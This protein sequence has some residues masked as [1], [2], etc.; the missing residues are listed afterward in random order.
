[1]LAVPG[2]DFAVHTD[3]PILS[4]G[5]YLD[6][7]RHVGNLLEQ[8]KHGE[9]RML[10]LSAVEVLH[11]P[12]VQA[13]LPLV[14]SGEIPHLQFAPCIDAQC[15]RCDGSLGGFKFPFVGTWCRRAVLVQ[16]GASADEAWAAYHGCYEEDRLSEAMVAEA[17]SGLRAQ[18][19]IPMY[20]SAIAGRVESGDLPFVSFR[21]F[22]GTWRRWS[23]GA[24][25]WTEP[26]PRESDS[27]ARATAG[28]L[29]RGWLDEGRRNLPL[30][31]LC[32]YCGSRTHS[33]CASCGIHQC[34][35]CPIRCCQGSTLGGAALS[36][37]VSR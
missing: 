12:F 5:A 24:R 26:W 11:A 27:L 33:V 35:A 18:D 9:A 1:M 8:G 17:G 22:M 16:E 10:W 32:A 23:L 15:A 31:G 37:G 21:G 30:G 25:R 6:F 13:P 29:L 3:R 7:K 19:I 20:V 4:T 14:D 28:R 36:H 2:V 34:E